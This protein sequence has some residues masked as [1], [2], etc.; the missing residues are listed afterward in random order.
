MKNYRY[1]RTTDSTNKL[2]KQ[3]LSVGKLPAFYAVRAGFQSAG[4]GQ[5]GNSWESESGANI[6]CSILLYPHTIALE[7]HFILSQLVSVAIVNVLRRFQIECK[8][9]WPNDIYWNDRKIGGVLIE[10]SLRSG[11]IE[12]SIIGVGLNINQK[13]FVSNA[14]NPVS[15]RQITGKKYSLRPLFEEL[16][17]EV[18]KMYHTGHAEIKSVYLENLYRGIT[19]YPFRKPGGETF[20]A[21]INSIAD[22]GCLYLETT[23]GLQDGYYFKEI[24]FVI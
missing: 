16:V 2:M 8:I 4:K 9:K 11:R 17:S 1:V 22:D 3:M 15:V 19:Y 20:Q 6:L 23:N 18:E 7:K 24:E 10:N 5:A 21:R 12:N 13:V 14:P